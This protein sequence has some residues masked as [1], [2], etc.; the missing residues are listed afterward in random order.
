MSVV[1]KH[2]FPAVPAFFFAYTVRNWTEND[3][4]RFPF[5]HSS[6]LPVRFTVAARVLYFLGAWISDHLSFS[7]PLDNRYD[8]YVS[9]TTLHYIHQPQ[10]IEQTGAQHWHE[11]SP[12]KVG[13]VGFVAALR[14]PV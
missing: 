11:S 12:P 8:F 14:P 13:F 5:Q 2:I 9:A 3:V 10:G 6:G 4:D 7:N 1:L